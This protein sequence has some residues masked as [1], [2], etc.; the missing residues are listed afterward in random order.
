MKREKKPSDLDHPPL[1]RHA[2]GSS[3]PRSTSPRLQTDEASAVKTKK[4]AAHRDEE[5]PSGNSEPEIP[6]PPHNR[7]GK[8]DGVRHEAPNTTDP[9]EPEIGTRDALPDPNDCLLDKVVGVKGVTR[10]QLEAGKNQINRKNNGRCEVGP[11]QIGKSWEDGLRGIEDLAYALAKDRK[12]SS[13]DKVEVRHRRDWNDLAPELQDK[14]RR[15]T[16]HAK[17]IFEDLCRIQLLYVARIWHTI[18]EQLFSAGP[19]SV[20][21]WLGPHWARFAE[22]KEAFKGGYEENK[23]GQSLLCLPH[24][25]F[26]P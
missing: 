6:D 16:S 23:K 5:A 4:P 10:L 12:R 1:K 25:V 14:L 7:P 26:I 18:D 20:Q 22:L 3:A 2:M 15:W 19:E 11:E 9:D 8:P 24:F 17:E 21:E 13:P